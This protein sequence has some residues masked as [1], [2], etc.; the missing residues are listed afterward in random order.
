MASKGQKLSEE[1]KRKIGKSNSISL[2]DRRLSEETK[3]KISL[4]HKGKKP[5][6]L[7]L[8]HI[9]R[10]GMKHSNESKEKM[11]KSHIGKKIP[12]E[13]KNKMSNSH[14]GKKKTKEHCKAI[15]R[16]RRGMKFSEEHRKK[17]SE[18]RKGKPV[19]DRTGMV[20][21][22]KGKK[23][24]RKEVIQKFREN[25]LNTLDKMKD[26]KRISKAEKIIAKWLDYKKIKYKQQFKY[27]LGRADFYLP[28]YNIIIECYGSYWHSK[29]NYV[30]R[31]KKKNKWLKDNGYKIIILN[32]E[33]V[34]MNS[35]KI[36]F[37]EEFNKPYDLITPMDIYKSKQL[38]DV[39]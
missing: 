15:S 36:D 23:E 6:N 1:T 37:E 32:S 20:P 17:L 39:K 22:N 16:G 9:L 4:T 19:F 28:E 3:R 12:L 5:K 2:K 35:K 24:T 25:A 38:K 14:K 11:S 21:W 18:I 29:Q 26:N 7:Q 8:L 13:I 30:E 10:K 33:E 27:P 34:V 31:D